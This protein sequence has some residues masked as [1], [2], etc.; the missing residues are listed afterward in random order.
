MV[1]PLMNVRRWMPPLGLA[2]TTVTTGAAG[3]AGL[4]VVVVVGPVAVAVPLVGA[5]AVAVAAESALEDVSSPPPLA[6][7]NAATSTTTAPRTIAMR[8][9]EDMRHNLG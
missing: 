9:R 5:G 3:T 7:T 4:A 6:M 2:S 8:A 1:S